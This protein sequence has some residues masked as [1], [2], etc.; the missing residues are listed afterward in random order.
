MYSVSTWTP[1]ELHDK[2]KIILMMK[3]MLFKCRIWRICILY[4]TT[5]QSQRSEETLRWHASESQSLKENPK[6]QMSSPRGT[7]ILYLLKFLH[8]NLHNIWVLLFSYV[9]RVSS[10]SICNVRDPLLFASAV[11]PFRHQRAPEGTET[12]GRCP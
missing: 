2:E 10:K 8:N 3:D 1:T 11:L 12:K 6:I 4:W 5:G 9:T 7:I